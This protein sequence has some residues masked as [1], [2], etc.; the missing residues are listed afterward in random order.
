[1]E[2]GKTGFADRR[3]VHQVQ[4]GGVYIVQRGA[5]QSTESGQEAQIKALVSFYMENAKIIRATDSR[6]MAVYGE[7]GCALRLVKTPNNLSG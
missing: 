4:W 7:R 2:R 3:P 6:R 1:M 5:G